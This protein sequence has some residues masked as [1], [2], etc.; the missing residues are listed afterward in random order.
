MIFHIR[1]LLVT[2]E[3]AIL[4]RGFNFYACNLRLSTRGVHELLKFVTVLLIRFIMMQLT[5]PF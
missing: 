3:T 4:S 2:M 1:L 5:S